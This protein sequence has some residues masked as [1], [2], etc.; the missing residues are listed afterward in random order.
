[1][2]NEVI[3]ATSFAI[4]PWKDRG[5]ESKLRLPGH[6]EAWS[7]AFPSSLPIAQAV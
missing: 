6:G 4:S 1:M 7:F 2:A 5:S 3:P